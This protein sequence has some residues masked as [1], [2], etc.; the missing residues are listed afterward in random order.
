MLLDGLPKT[1]QKHNA[2]TKFFALPNKG[3]WSAR[4][5]CFLFFSVSLS[6]PVFALGL[7]VAVV[8]SVMLF[9]PCLSA[10]LFQPLNSTTSDGVFATQEDVQFELQAGLRLDLVLCVRVYF[11]FESQFELQFAMHV[12][13]YYRI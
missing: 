2:S 1:I 7:A 10:L 11:D 8:A 5:G 9:A 4:S 3:K 6:V 12:H 13:V